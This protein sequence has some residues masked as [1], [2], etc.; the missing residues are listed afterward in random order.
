[1]Y[2]LAVACELSEGSGFHAGELTLAIGEERLSVR[3]LIAATVRTQIALR[4]AMQAADPAR[5]HLDDDAIKR[6]HR[7]G[8]I[9]LASRPVAD[10]EVEHEIE[11]ALLAFEQ[12][13][14]QIVVDG[15]WLRELDQEVDLRSTQR[16]VFLR[17]MPLRGG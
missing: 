10:P 11:R 7:F 1:M 12:R 16:M 8:R 6:Q 15:H 5:D 13:A 2:E 14:Y 9:A 4:K 17:L 3:A